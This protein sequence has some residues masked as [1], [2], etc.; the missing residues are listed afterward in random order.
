[1]SYNGGI[2]YG[3]LADY[4]A[5]PDIDLIAE[6]IQETLDEL[7]VAVAGRPSAVKS[8]VSAG[9]RPAGSGKASSGAGSEVDSDGANGSNGRSVPLLPTS[10]G[11]PHRGPAADMRAKRTRRSPR[12][13]RS[14]EN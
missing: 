2:D 8:T 7:L 12:P 3:L 14:P 1:M 11:R 5:L 9:A 4:D 13:P 10:P 6:G